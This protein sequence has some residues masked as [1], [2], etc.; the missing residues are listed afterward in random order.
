[1]SS[2]VLKYSRHPRLYILP[3]PPCRRR[4]RDGSQSQPSTSNRGGFST[5]APWLSI[6]AIPA[7]SC[8]EIDDGGGAGGA[9]SGR[10]KLRLEGSWMVA[11]GHRGVESGYTPSQANPTAA[12]PEAEASTAGAVAEANTTNSAVN[13]PKTERPLV[14]KQA[15]ICWITA[16]NDDDDD[17]KE[18]QA[19]AVKR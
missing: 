16:D 14:E 9:G 18:G 17:A 5:S 12:A 19:R 13:A 6:V 10:A 1:M 15:A 4:R 7:V 2:V 3:L 8:C 11:I